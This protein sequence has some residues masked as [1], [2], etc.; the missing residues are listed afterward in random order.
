MKRLIKWF[1]DLFLSKNKIR[2]RYNLDLTRL[3]H[4][5]DIKTLL[6]VLLYSKKYN[7][8]SVLTHNSLNPNLTNYKSSFY[9]YNVLEWLNM[10]FDESMFSKEQRY[11]P[12]ELS[13]RKNI[14]KK[15]L[16]EL[17]KKKLAYYAFE[18]KEEL[19]K[20]KKEHKNFQYKSKKYKGLKNSLTLSEKEVKEYLKNKIPY[21]IRLNVPNKI[22][23]ITNGNNETLIDLSLIADKVI[24]KSETELPTEFFADVIDDKLMKISH[25]VKSTH[26]LFDVALHKMLSNI[27]FNYEPNYIFVEGLFDENTNGR[28]SSTK[29]YNYSTNINAF[30]EARIEP[31][32]FI[33]QLYGMCDIDPHD[34]IYIEHLIEVFDE[35]KFKK[36]T[37][38]NPII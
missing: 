3:L 20:L 1:K 18:S 7:G 34:D 6:F 11:G 13:K 9:L 27:L 38:Y 2:L 28:I 14:Y 35:E 32:M 19:E 25:I 5:G 36:P 24:W 8:V 21:V 22:I 15:Y 4:L 30:I 16:N 23:K 37:I 10:S 12:Y 31:E 17:I 33:A 26:Q 29:S